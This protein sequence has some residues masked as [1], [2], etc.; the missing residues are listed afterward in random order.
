MRK[1]QFFIYFLVVIAMVFPLPGFHKQYRVEKNF[2]LS[3]KLTERGV[4]YLKKG[5]MTKAEKF[6]K[7]AIRKYSENYLAYALLAEIFFRKK[8]FEKSC[9]FFSKSLKFFPVY[10]KTYVDMLKKQILKL[11]TRRKKI[12]DYLLFTEKHE[13]ETAEYMC[14]S[15]GMVQ[16]RVEKDREIMHKKRELA[17]IAKKIDFLKKKIKKIETL[18]YDNN[19]I[20]NYTVCLI[21]TGKYMSAIDNCK[22]LLNRRFRLTDTYSL[23]IMCYVLKGDCKNALKFKKQA[24]SQKVAINSKT[25]KILEQFCP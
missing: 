17:S 20:L 8:N 10:K 11:E 16:L 9:Y 22:V 3:L 12:E 18:N 5:K 1:I 23:L 13:P 4:Y 24:F 14:G 21:N 7:R 2:A 6:F 15:E 19:F 25:K